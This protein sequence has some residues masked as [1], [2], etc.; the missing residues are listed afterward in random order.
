[1]APVPT[2]PNPS[3]GSE[4]SELELAKEVL[5]VHKIRWA[6]E[7]GSGKYLGRPGLLS[8]RL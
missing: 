6:Q 3:S 8:H 2:G 7:S 4:E 5:A 1:M